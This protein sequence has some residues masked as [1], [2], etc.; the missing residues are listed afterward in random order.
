MAKRMTQNLEEVAGCPV[1]IEEAEK[2]VFWR[3]VVRELKAWKKGFGIE[4]DGI[5]DDASASNPSTA[6]VLMHM[7]SI[8]GRV[9]AVDYLLE[10][11]NVFKSIL[12]DKEND[13]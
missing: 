12:E 10:L 5:V 2:S 11:P 6:S 4:Q 9:K 8:D 7:G 3:D 13:S 1:D